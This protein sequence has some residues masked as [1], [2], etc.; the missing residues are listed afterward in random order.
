LVG[1]KAIG[2]RRRE[3]PER[4][5]GAS[6]I[7]IAIALAL[8]PRLILMDEPTSGVSIDR[9]VPGDGD[10]DPRARCPVTAVFVEH[11]MDVVARLRRPRRVWTG[12]RIAHQGRRR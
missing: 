4:G 3:L 8:K 5:H 7:D 9:E 11:D 1:L 2:N 12:G 6:S 10:A